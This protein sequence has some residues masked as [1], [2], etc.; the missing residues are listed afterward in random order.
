MIGTIAA[1]GGNVPWTISEPAGSLAYSTTD[2]KTGTVATAKP[3]IY[4]IPT[5]VK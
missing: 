2:A 5:Y 4:A 3:V 1:N